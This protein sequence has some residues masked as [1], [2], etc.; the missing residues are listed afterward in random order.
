MHDIYQWRSLANKLMNPGCTSKAE[1]LL[2]SWET[3][4]FSRS[5]LRV[6]RFWSH[7]CNKQGT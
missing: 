3:V 6:V 1:Y 5:T 4:S 2:S 7:L